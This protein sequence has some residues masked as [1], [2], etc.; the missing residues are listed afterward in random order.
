MGL[1]L[2]NGVYT[3][4]DLIKISNKSG[5]NIRGLMSKYAKDVK[6][7]ILENGKSYANYSWDKEHFSKLFYEGKIEKKQL[8]INTNSEL[9]TKLEI[10]KKMKYANVPLS[11]ILDFT[12]LT[13]EQIKK[14]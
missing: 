6:Y 3:V 4:E 13:K 2:K 12:S 1:S 14:I 9:K 5:A 8:N 10:A 11:D 7:K